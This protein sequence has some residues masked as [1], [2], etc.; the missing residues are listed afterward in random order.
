MHQSGL[1]LFF[2]GQG[3]QDAFVNRTLGDEMLNDDRFG[4]LPLPPQ[5]G[6][7]LLVEFQTPGQAKLHQHISACLQ[8]Q[9]MTSSGRMQQTNL[10]PSGVPVPNTVGGLDF[11]IGNIQLSQSLLNP[12]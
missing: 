5:S 7:G 12:L 3:F 6:I 11:L 2:L 10:Q 1:G 9:A 4:L 8:F